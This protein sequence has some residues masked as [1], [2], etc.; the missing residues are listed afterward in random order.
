MSEWNYK[1]KMAPKLTDEFKEKFVVSIKGKEAIKA[2]GLTALAHE[3]GLWKMETDV[4]QFPTQANNFVAICKTTVGGYDWDPVKNELREVEYTDIADASPDNVTSM[5][6]KSYIR[7]ASTRSIA[8]ALR[9]YTNV[10]ILCSSELDSAVE[11]NEPLITSAQ[12][13]VIKNLL[14]QLGYSR[15][16]FSEEITQMFTKAD[17]MLLT[18]KEADQ[19][20]KHL[21]T[22]KNQNQNQ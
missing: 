19:Y 22:V 11:N 15:E 20:I 10:D 2:E 8:R 13:G 3:K 9:K 18:L 6:A 5:V 21:N 1:D 7:M 16:K 4:I 12:A 17:F 14:H